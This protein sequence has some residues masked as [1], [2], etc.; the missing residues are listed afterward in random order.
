MI[1][2][3]H[4]L[5]VMFPCRCKLPWN[6]DTFSIQNEVHELYVNRSIPWATKDPNHVYSQCSLYKDSVSYDTTGHHPI[7]NSTVECDEWV[8]DK[9]VF[10]TTFTSQVVLKFKRANSC[11]YQ[12]INRICDP[13]PIH[14]TYRDQKKFSCINVRWVLREMC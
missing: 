2:F 10:K 11:Y 6:N 5:N 14:Y 9:S 4:F 12:G 1:Q 3:I 8:Y 7:N 13:R